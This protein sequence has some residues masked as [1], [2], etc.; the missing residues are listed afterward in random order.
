MK[1]ITIPMAD[2]PIEIII[3][4]QVYVYRAGETVTV[5]DEVAAAIEQ[6]YHMAPGADNKPPAPE[7]KEYPYDVV[8]MVTYSEDDA[9]IDVT[10]DPVLLKGDLEECMAALEDG[11]IFTTAVFSMTDADD[12]PVM[13]LFPVTSV[14]LDET[15]DVI[16]LYISGYEIAWDEDGLEIVAPPDPPAD[17]SGT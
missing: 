13:H 15:D 16:T 5:T 4:N 17:N 11:D 7:V 3:N 8:I 9:E 10:E 2:N 12:G 14:A 1:T 6:I